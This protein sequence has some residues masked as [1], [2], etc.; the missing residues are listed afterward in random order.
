MKKIIFYLLAVVSIGLSGCSNGNSRQVIHLNNLSEE[1]DFRFFELL[2][3]E[4]IVTVSINLHRNQT[5]IFWR[6]NLQRDFIFAV[7]ESC[8]LEQFEKENCVVIS[9]ETG[10]TIGFAFLLP[11][12]AETAKRIYPGHMGYPEPDDTHQGSCSPFF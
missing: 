8:V 12:D 5:T 4:R 10:H 2:E 11:E 6:S 1:F 3:N 7:N 9:A